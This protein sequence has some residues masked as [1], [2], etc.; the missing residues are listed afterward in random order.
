MYHQGTGD[1]VSPY[2]IWIRCGRGYVE[3]YWESSTIKCVLLELQIKIP[4]Y[5]H[6]KLSTDPRI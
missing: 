2:D 3:N 6:F 4:K 1:V 5:V